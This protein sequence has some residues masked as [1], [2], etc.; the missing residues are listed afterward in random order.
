M[1]RGG[2]CRLGQALFLLLQVRIGL[3]LR[4]GLGF[5]L[6]LEMPPGTTMLTAPGALCA[7]CAW[8][9]IAGGMAEG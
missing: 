4:V 3:G 9:A 1:I 7:L 8:G 2:R 5:G 6:G